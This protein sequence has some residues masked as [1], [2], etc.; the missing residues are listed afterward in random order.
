MERPYRSVAPRRPRWNTRQ[1]RWTMRIVCLHRARSSRDKYFST[2]STEGVSG[3]AALRDFEPAFDRSRSN[4]ELASGGLMSAPPSYGHSRP[5]AYVR[6][7]PRG[8]SK[9]G[10]YS[11]VSSASASSLGGT[12]IPSAVAVLRLIT[13]STLV[14][15][16]TGRSEGFTPLRILPT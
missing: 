12:S 7:V 5:R 1:C 2:I 15:C 3:F 10:S 8:C 11:I 6:E 16:S 4:P 9:Q 14:G 13:N